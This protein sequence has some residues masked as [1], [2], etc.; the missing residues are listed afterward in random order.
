MVGF[1]ERDAA[2][3]RGIT[4]VEDVFEEGRGDDIADVFGD[5]TSWLD[6]G[7]VHLGGHGLKCS[8]IVVG[9]DEFSEL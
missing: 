3:V 1:L 5:F 6:C 4:V 7:V 2:G 8:L 9:S